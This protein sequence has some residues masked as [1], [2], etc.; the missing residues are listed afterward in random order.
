MT[1][2]M[3][4][5]ATTPVRREVLMTM[6][7][8]LSFKFGNA[9]SLHKL[10][11]EARDALEESRKKIAKILNAR[12]EEI[13]FT[14]GGTESNNFAL[15]GIVAFNR[16]RG[17]HIITSKIEHPSVLN[18]LKI[19]EKLH[20]MQVT[21]LDV[22]DKGMVNPRD[23]ENAITDKTI[24]VTIMHA[25]N[26]IGTIQQIAEI[27]KIC[28]KHNVL[29]HTDAVQTFGKEMTDV[30]ELK[31]DALSASGHKIYGPKGIGF[32]YI[33]NG[34]RINPLFHGGE[35]ER[36]M[37]SGTENIPGIIGMAKAAE[38]ADKERINENKRLI[39]LRDKLIHEILKIKGTRLNGHEKDR[40]AN[41]VNVSFRNIEGESVLLMLDKA[42]IAASTGSA[43]STKS[44]E[45]SHVLLAIGLS[46][47]DAH[48]SLRLTLGKSTNDAQI[49]KTI[50]EIK[51][52]VEKLRKISP[53]EK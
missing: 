25:N 36:G 14:S 46:H 41:N 3:D 18:T 8:Y 19:I 29:F 48:G 28:K 40:L 23:V 12:P 34:I 6:F 45:P 43:C 47:K 42:G 51:K 21:Y 13:Y 22:D 4:H 20:G 31:C 24:L 52:I 7:P 27:G 1:I 17:N 11:R 2:Y 32:I 15:K 33:R 38:L 16:D 53:F 50:S 37:R 10:G 49:N 35:Q 9:S 44:L 26:E 39:K 5:A 30:K